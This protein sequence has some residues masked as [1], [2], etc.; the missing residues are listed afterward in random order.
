MS[1]EASA[2]ESVLRL[3]DERLAWRETGTEVVVLDLRGSVYFS[4]NATAAR[5]WT[6]LAQGATRTG[7]VHRLVEEQPVGSARAE[8]DVDAF[9]AALADADLLRGPAAR[10]R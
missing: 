9:L 5:L 1:G 6:L 3:D 4:L 7:L 8:A 2:D 10:P